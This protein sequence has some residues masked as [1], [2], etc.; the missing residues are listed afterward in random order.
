MDVNFPAMR[1]KMGYHEYYVAM[2]KLGDVVSIFE[3]YLE[4][5][6][7]QSQTR[8][9]IDLLEEAQR[10][11]N[12][13]RIPEIKDYI[14][15]NPSNWVFS[16][17]TAS[18]KDACFFPFEPNLNIGT[19]H[20]KGFSKFTINDGQHRCAALKEALKD[21]PRLE[22][23][24]ISV[25]FFRADSIQRMQQ[26]FTDLNRS[27]AKVSGSVVVAMGSLPIERATVEVA[28]ANPFLRTYT[29]MERTSPLLGSDKLFALS[30]LF[31]ANINFVGK[32]LKQ[33]DLDPAVKKLSKFWS[34]LYAEMPLW[35]AVENKEITPAEVKQDYIC[36]HA[37]ILRSLATLLRI[38]DQK[39]PLIYQRVLKQIGTLN[40]KKKERYWQGKA[41]NEN[42]SVINS[43]T[44]E[45]YVVASLRSKFGLA[46]ELH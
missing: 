43:R 3:T 31:Q 32:H 33:M 35:Q 5:K 10:R 17:L 9:E 2:I 21:D 38:A 44:A 11:M 13:R 41:V 12:I 42:G 40:W 16:A 25:V 36:N 20:F 15:G 7:H 28:S 30:A 27:A 29:E 37:M 45:S 14:L 6:I 24:T 1:G 4:K 46:S 23:Q 26:I 22:E 39:G 18:F 8:A 34:D 19:L